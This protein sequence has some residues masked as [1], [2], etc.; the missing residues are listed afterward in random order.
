VKIQYKNDTSALVNIRGKKLQPGESIV[1]QVFIK[2]FE[3]F[4]KKGDLTIYVDGVKI[5]FEQIPDVEAQVANGEPVGIPSD[6]KT[7]GTAAGET[8]ESA[9][10][11]KSEETPRVTAS[12]APAEEKTEETGEAEAVE[13]NE[14]ITETAETEAVAEDSAETFDANKATETEA[15]EK[16]AEETVAEAVAGNEVIGNAE[17]ETQK[18]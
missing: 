9:G 1:S 11:E 15:G 10:P 16:P 5:S 8:P 2:P 3:E 18:E 12:E 17:A 6:N 4:V 7:P 13:G 14:S